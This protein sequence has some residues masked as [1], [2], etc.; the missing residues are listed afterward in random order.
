VLIVVTWAA[1]Y[2]EAPLPEFAQL[3]SAY[4]WFTALP[5]DRKSTWVTRMRRGSGIA[6]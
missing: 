6:G 5:A 1:G 4:D 3:P 2:S